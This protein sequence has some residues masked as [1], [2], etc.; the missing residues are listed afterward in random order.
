MN[1]TT[2]VLMIFA[3]CLAFAAAP[4]FAHTLVP[5]GSAPLIDGTLAEGEWSDALSVR[6]SDEAELFLKHADGW[7]YLGIQAT[8]MGVGSPL[9]VRGE[10]V[11]VL[12][13]SAALATAI[14]VRDGDAWSLRQDFAWQCRSTG[15][16]A[17]ARAERAR[18]LQENGWLGTIG[19]LGD[20]TQFE[21]QI[22]WGDEP[23]TFLFLF[24]DFT[25]TIHLLS[26]PI[27]T[28]DA[29]RYEA[30]ITASPTP[31]RMQFDIGPWAVLE[32]GE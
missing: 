8:T 32:K 22:A 12:H 16:S 18:F 6:L 21:Y 23:L 25:D 9:I 7:L 11:L 5:V 13:A 28:T 20:P 3:A 2:V 24:A 26:W 31:L 14:Y 17:A 4:L 1:R 27:P 15:F 19:F 29:A 10:E 30:V